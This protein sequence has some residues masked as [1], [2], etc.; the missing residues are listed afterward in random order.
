[1][2]RDG[3]AKHESSDS[4]T[5]YR[6]WVRESGEGAA[7]PPVPK[8]LS[9]DDVSKQQASQTNPS[10]GSVWNKAGT[11]EEKNLN[12]WASSRIKVH[13]L[14]NITRCLLFV[15]LFLIIFKLCRSCLL[16]WAA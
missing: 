15:I 1:M 7:P 10:L 6:Y 4:S 2:E 16:L 11:W 12:A 14:K 13:V 5:N 8:K 9:A 3:I